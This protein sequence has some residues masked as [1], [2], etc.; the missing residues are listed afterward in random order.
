MDNYPSL[1]RYYANGRREYMDTYSL[2][3]KGKT[4]LNKNSLSNK[5]DKYIPDSLYKKQNMYN[6][7]ITFDDKY[8]LTLKKMSQIENREVCPISEY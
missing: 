2:T 5:K 6:D 7:I 4:A 3:L 1:N 8:F